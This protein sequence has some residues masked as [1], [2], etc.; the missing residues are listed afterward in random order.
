[1]TSHTLLSTVVGL[2]ALTLA[3]CSSKEPTASALPAVY[4]TEAV[5]AHAAQVRTLPATLQPR[6][7]SELGF[8]VGGQ[9]ATRRVALGTT[10]KQGDVLAELDSADYRLALEAARQQLRA[11][12]V[13]AQQSRQDAER[14]ERLA[15]DDTLGRADAE[16]QRAHADAT[17]ARLEQAQQQWALE[18]NRLEHTRLKAPFDG[19]VT[20]VQADVGQVVPEGMP[21]LTLAKAGEMEAWVDVPEHLVARIRSL[22][23]SVQ[24]VD[25]PEAAPVRGVLREVSAAAQAPART[26]RVR[27]ALAQV[28]AG[29]KLGRSVTVT[30]SGMAAAPATAKP[31]L[32]ELPVT[33]LVNQ[34]AATQVWWVDTATGQLRAQPVQ[35]QQQTQD[36]VV[37]L[38]VP[39]GA[40]VVSVGAHK[41]DAGMKVRPVVR[42]TAATVQGAGT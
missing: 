37:V 27:Y 38:G 7:E 26:F 23:A 11:A 41:L 31:P 8:R 10:V 3:A 35:V 39:V 5:S 28:P 14:F 36:R 17:Q 9:I 1:M 18:R 12:E 22:S 25:A 16:R 40:Q 32:V 19:V 21:V 4:V 33:A 2:L 20:A 15:A 6:V 42:P 29:W 34:G 13:D 30:L 24:L